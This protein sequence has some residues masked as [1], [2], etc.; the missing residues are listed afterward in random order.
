MSGIFPLNVKPELTASKPT[1][2]CCEFSVRGTNM[3]CE[4]EFVIPRILL[5][6]SFYG[7]DLIEVLLTV[8]NVWKMLHEHNLEGEQRRAT[9][10]ITGVESFS[11]KRSLKDPGS[12][13][14]ENL[15]KCCDGIY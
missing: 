7:H 2:H 4:V 12:N 14:L 1:Y 6:F 8:V 5:L 11:C 9:L 3:S 13:N 15:V 10:M